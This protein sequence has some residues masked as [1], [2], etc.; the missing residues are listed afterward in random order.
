[1]ITLYFR[2]WQG[3]RRDLLVVLFFFFCA[4]N[5]ATRLVGNGEVNADGA[6]QGRLRFKTL[7]AVFF[8]FLFLLLYR[9]V[10]NARANIRD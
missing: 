2:F 4:R 1:M 6:R 10:L 3:A 9:L 5:S 8:L 7:G